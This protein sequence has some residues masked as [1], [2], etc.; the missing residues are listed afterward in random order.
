MNHSPRQNF[1]GITLYMAI[2]LAMLAGLIVLLFS[3]SFDLTEAMTGWLLPLP[4]PT[5]LMCC[6]MALLLFYNC[7][8]VLSEI[9]SAVAGFFSGA[10]TI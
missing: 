3:R 9:A 7:L 2:M 1:I 5:Q 6:A 4:W 10:K 8:S